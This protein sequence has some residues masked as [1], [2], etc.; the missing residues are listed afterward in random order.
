[1]EKILNPK[2]KNVL[3]AAFFLLALL[4]LGLIL[5]TTGAARYLEEEKIQAFIR[6]W[7]IWA[8]LIYLLIFSIAPS[9][10]IP[11][12]P[13]TLAG[14]VIFGP[15]LGTAL[16]SAGSTIG[17]GVAF[18][19]ARYFARGQVQSL[20]GTKL[21]FINRGVTRRGWAFVAMTRLIPFFPYI[22][23]NYAFGLTRINFFEYL[24]TSWVCMFPHTVAFVF[25]SSSILHLL[26]GKLSLELWIG[27]GLI[28]LLALIPLVYRKYRKDKGEILPE[29][30]NQD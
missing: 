23:L 19:V 6:S 3:K 4:I 30:M 26:Q 15:I 20:L 25:F 27:L 5:R 14:G 29:N 9:L 28:I 10:L 16:A 11:A 8:P 24:L 1:M 13:I 21:D 7:G 12:L 17:A 18:L 22:L 2:V